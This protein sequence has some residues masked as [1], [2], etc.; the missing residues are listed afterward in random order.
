MD[1]L[2][3]GEI[4]QKNKKGKIIFGAIGIVLVIVISF[5]LGNIVSGFGYS[6]NSHIGLYSKQT[7]SDSEAQQFSTLFEV[8]NELENLYDG[9]I[10]EDTLV[11]GSVKGMTAALKDPYTIYMNSEEYKKYMESN[12]GE[13]MGIGVYIASKS[14]QVVVSSVISGAPAEKAGILAGDVIYSV[15]GDELAGDTQK[16]V[17]LMTGLEKK[18]VKLVIIR[19]G[20]EKIDMDVERDKIKTVSVTGDMVNDNI[21]YIYLSTFDLN[22]SADFTSKVKEFK[23]KGMKGLIIDLR[24]NG[25]GYVSEAVKIASQFIPKGKTITYTI[26]KYD[27]KTVSYSTGGID[28]GLPIVILTNEN[29]ASASELVTGALKDY[30]IATSVGTTTFGKGIVQL[31][32]ELNSGNG[33]LKVTVSKYYT[34]NGNNIH[35]IGIAPDY[36]VKLTE[37]QAKKNPYDRNNDPQFQKALEVIQEKTK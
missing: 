19:N 8:K 25:G 3:D 32:F 24:N 9:P 16:A 34:P 23:D 5:G 18:V 14:E 29:T 1:Q 10:D 15:D 17:S 7:V 28:E 4:K 33:G 36:E 13:F 11:E 35:K 27:K 12:S 6:V 31:P 2:K 26:D 37:D 21:G 22:V 20:T 30:G